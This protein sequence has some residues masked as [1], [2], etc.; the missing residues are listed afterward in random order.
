M[1]ERSIWQESAIALFENATERLS[2]DAQKLQEAVAWLRAPAT[3]AL[4][5]S[6]HWLSPFVRSASKRV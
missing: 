3:Y 6:A 4:T 2:G 5:T 1:S